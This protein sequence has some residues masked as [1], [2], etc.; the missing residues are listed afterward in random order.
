VKDGKPMLA[1]DPPSLDAQP[2]EYVQFNF[3][4]QNHTV[5][6]STFEKPCVK[7]QDGMDSGFMPNPN[8]T[9]PVPPSMMMAIN[10]TKP[11][12]KCW[13]VSRRF[14]AFV[15]Y[16]LSP[17]VLLSASNSLW[18]RHGVWHQSGQFRQDDAILGN[19]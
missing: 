15:A 18:E 6:Q 5:T 17:R 8:N 16:S 12:C 13:R 10:D 4:A 19:G 9:M 14:W 1:Y 2:G 7:M 11:L 3:K